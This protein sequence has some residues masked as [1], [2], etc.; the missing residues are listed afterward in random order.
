[1]QKLTER[2]QK[3]IIKDMAALNYFYKQNLNEFSHS[4]HSNANIIQVILDYNSAISLLQIKGVPA[5]IKFNRHTFGH[6]LAKI[7]DLGL[8][9]WSE[10]NTQFHTYVNYLAN[11]ANKLDPI[12]NKDIRFIFSDAFI[13]SAGYKA[14]NTFFTALTHFTDIFK[15]TI[16][17]GKTMIMQS[18][19][20]GDTYLDDFA[21]LFDREMTI[22]AVREFQTLLNDMVND[23]LETGDY[24]K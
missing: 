10:K 6:L 5:E 11:E 24:K 23:I 8:P 19:K 13:Q 22:L 4:I 2:V 12:Y 1:M 7:R 9:C 16:N 14:M 21:A 17:Y 20:V 18:V 15:N 3:D